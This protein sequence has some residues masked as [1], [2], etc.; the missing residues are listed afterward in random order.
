M[1]VGRNLDYRRNGV[2]GGCA[3]AGCEQ[4]YAGASSHL[5]GDTLDVISR[6][7][8]QVQTSYGRVFRVIQYRSDR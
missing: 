7:A 5:R 3:Q 2:P 1:V 4:D 6:S 8:L